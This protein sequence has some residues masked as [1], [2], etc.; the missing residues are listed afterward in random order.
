[1]SGVYVKLPGGMRTAGGRTGIECVG[2]TVR[3]VI[4]HLIARESCVRVR[5]FNADGSLR[6]AV[7]LNGH[8]VVTLNGLD[9]PVRDGDHLSLLPR[10]RGE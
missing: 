9:T 7:F 5:V 10:V 4:E 8:D 2:D 6:S 1:M 3:D